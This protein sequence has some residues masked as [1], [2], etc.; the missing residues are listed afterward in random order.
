VTRS[1]DVP[2]QS[3]GSTIRF[4]WSFIARLSVRCGGLFPES[5]STPRIVSPFAAH[6]LKLMVF[7]GGLCGHIARGAASILW[8]FLSRALHTWS[9]SNSIRTS[10]QLRSCTAKLHN[11]ALQTDERRVAVAASVKLTL[12]PLA[13]ERQNR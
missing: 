2:Q 12:A 7:P 1:G 10:K 5:C 9:C 6:F 4:T 3:F 8:Y 13:A 11:K